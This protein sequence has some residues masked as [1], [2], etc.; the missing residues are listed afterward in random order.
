MVM[1]S[2]RMIYD[3]TTAHQ[4]GESSTDRILGQSS[5]NPVDFEDN[6]YV[7]YMYG[8]LGSSTYEETHANINNS[9]IKIAVDNWYESVF[10]NTAYE[11][12]LADEIFCNDRSFSS[13]NTGTGI[14]SSD[15][16][17]RWYGDTGGSAVFHATNFKCFYQND[18]FTVDD[19]RIGN[20]DLTYPIGLITADELQINN[21]QFSY[22]DSFWTMTP[23]HFERYSQMRGWGTAWE[24]PFPVYSSAGIKPVINL[25]PNSLNTGDGSAS[26]PYRIEE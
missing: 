6:A 8:I 10:L 15:T 4:N 22:E 18:R 16:L 14:G 19:E 21:P 23:S 9:I 1:A 5:Y 24:I 7:G 17:Y 25:K 2:L 20:G 3:G 26:N 11:Q 12:Y 13:D